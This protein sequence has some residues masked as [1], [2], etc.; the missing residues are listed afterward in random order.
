MFCSCRSNKKVQVGG[1]LHCG[2]A[3]PYG[4]IRTLRALQVISG[5]VFIGM[6]GFCFYFSAI[7]LQ[8]ILR[9]DKVP[10][11]IFA[12]LLTVGGI[13]AAGGVSSFFGRSWLFRL[14][15]AYSVVL[16]RSGPRRKQ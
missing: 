11:A 10:W 15:L 1:C 13:L 12:I 16:R 3:W 9:G 8:D 14:L 6:S 7:A 2:T 5:V 4:E